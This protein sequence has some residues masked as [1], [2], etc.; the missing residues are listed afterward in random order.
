MRTILSG[1]S[2]VSVAPRWRDLRS[3]DSWLVVLLVLGLGL[4]LL[5]LLQSLT[6]FVSMFVADDF[7][8][9]AN[10]AFQIAHGHGSTFDGGI[11]HHNGYHPLFLWLL[12]PG[13]ALGLSKSAMIIFGMVILIVAWLVVIVLAYHLGRSLGATWGAL[14]APAILALN[15]EFAKVSLSGFETALAALFVLAVLLA[16]QQR[17]SGWVIGG[18]LG[19]AGLARLD[20]A[21]L[22][23]PVTIILAT[24]RRWRDLLISGAVAAVIVA[25]WCIWSW[26]VFGSP[27]PLSGV[28]KSW[29]GGIAGLWEGPLVF[30]RESFY[31]LI[32]YSW[33]RLPADLALAAGAMAV[34]TALRRGWSQAWLAIFAIATPAAFAV[35]TGAHLLPQFNRYCVPAFCVL[36]VLLFARPARLAPV[37]LLLVVVSV[38]W[39]DR[40]FLAWSLRTPP[41]QNYVGCC[42]RE[43]PDIIAAIA[44]PDDL[45]GS[46]DSGSLG[47]FCDRPIVN[48]DGLAN[49][50]IA[51]LLSA[52]AGGTWRRR[53]RSYFQDK[54][55]TILVGG[56]A[57]SWIRMFPDLQEWPLA[58]EPVPL[59]QGARI[60]FR[61]V[62]PLGS[63]PGTASGRDVD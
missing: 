32:G 47:Y 41:L 31:R 26:L 55:I 24:E 56:S 2:A 44:G 40:Q 19:L 63:G 46:F 23:L 51:P 25:P 27:L 12:V 57:F 15:I 42:Q 43:A 28:V 17:R 35:L 52:P 39:G 59:A 9:Y 21:F 4:R 13:Y 49:S 16:C 20:N 33:R 58:H 3:P 22:V 18:L 37:I 61:R 45:V 29:H 36:A 50:D 7:F 8:Y 54:G 48:L 14:T 5:F 34:L 62:P 11:T 1:Q 38:A 6:W 60:V 10:T 30:A 53:Y